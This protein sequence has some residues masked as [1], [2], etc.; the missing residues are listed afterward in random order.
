MNRYLLAGAA[1]IA[2]GGASLAADITAEP[3]PYDWSGFYFGANAGYGG[4]DVD[5]TF[6]GAI[7]GPD[8]TFAVD[9]RGPFDLNLDGLVGGL[10]AGGNWQNGTFVIGVEADVSLVDWSDSVHWTE[11]CCGNPSD[12]LSAETDFVATLRGRAGVA[13]D[14]VLLF[15]T[16]GVAFTDTNYT[17]DEKVNATGRGSLDFD[18]V[19]FVVG[20]G[21]EYALSQSWSI[22]AEGLYFFFNDKEDASDLT[23]GNPATDGDS[24]QLDNAWMARVGVNFRL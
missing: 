2:M 1:F 6:R 5:G 20:G 11:D 4:A 8:D 24:V 17:A 18:D 13:M 7:T 22:K 16:A 9:G 19:G 15:G 14:N 23:G 21:A 3:A 12:R 10:Q